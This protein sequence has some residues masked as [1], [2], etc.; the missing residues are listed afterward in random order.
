MAEDVRMGE[1]RHR[2]GCWGDI[3]APGKRQA[4]HLECCTQAY[5]SRSIKYIQGR[6]LHRSMN[7]AYNLGKTRDG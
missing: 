2:Y 4:E 3:D 7:A 1:E 6:T 5:I